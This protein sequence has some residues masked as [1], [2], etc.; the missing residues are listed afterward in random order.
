MPSIDLSAIMSTAKE[1]KNENQTANE[2]KLAVSNGL[3]FDHI[4]FLL[5]NVYMR[6]AIWRLKI[7][8]QG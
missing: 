6:V 1:S 5:G 7:E 4:L 3:F 2:R 8:T